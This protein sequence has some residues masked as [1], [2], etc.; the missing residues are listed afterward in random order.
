M[1]RDPEKLNEAASILSN[2]CMKTDF[3]CSENL[4]IAE[5][6]LEARRQQLQRVQLHPEYFHSHAQMVKDCPPRLTR[7]KIWQ[8]TGMSFRKISLGQQVVF[9][10][11]ASSSRNW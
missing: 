7:R 10:S 8:G 6:M 4:S 11:G 5:S 3:N 9:R 1:G 2:P